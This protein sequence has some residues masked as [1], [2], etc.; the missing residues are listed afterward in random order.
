M[1]SFFVSLSLANVCLPWQLHK[2]YAVLWALNR[3]VGSETPKYNNFDQFWKSWFYLRYFP[4]NTKFL[5]FDGLSNYL[6]LFKNH[7]Q[8][9]SWQAERRSSHFKV[10]KIWFGPSIKL[11]SKS[12]FADFYCR[13]GISCFLLLSL[14][15]P[16]PFPSSVIAEWSLQRYIILL[17]CVMISWVNGEKYENLLQVH[18]SWLASLRMY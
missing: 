4:R 9:F 12:F 17:Y 18:T 13:V 7:R 2:A 14:S 6:Y 15:T 8:T 10:T 11:F 16:S 3:F 1:F 5:S